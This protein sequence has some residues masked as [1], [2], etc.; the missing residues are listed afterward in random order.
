MSDRLKGKSAVVTGGANVIG[1]SISLA[2]AA[3]GAKVPVADY[4]VSRGGEGS[5]TAPAGKVV[6]EIKSEGGYAAAFFGSVV[7]FKKAE[8]TIDSCVKNFGRIGTGQS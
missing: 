4:G 5:D 3:E 1:R 2:F 6:A 7:D 8:E